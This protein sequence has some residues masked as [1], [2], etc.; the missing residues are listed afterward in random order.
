LRAR[1]PAWFAAAPEMPELVRT[2]LKKAAAGD[3]DAARAAQSQA[4]AAAAAHAAS[5]NRILA[6]GGAA[7]LVAAAILYGLDASGPRVGAVPFSAI[8]IAVLA[9]VAFAAAWRRSR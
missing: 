6:L 4:G 7:A 5:R 8:A 2:W 1:L 3:F 9:A